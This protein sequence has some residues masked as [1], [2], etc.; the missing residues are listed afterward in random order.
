MID[1]YKRSYLSI[2][3]KIVYARLSNAVL[4][5]EALFK[6]ADKILRKIKDNVK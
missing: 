4:E 3:D 5:E 6:K 1:S 2:L